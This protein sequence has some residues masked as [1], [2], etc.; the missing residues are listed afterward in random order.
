LEEVGVEQKKAN[1]EK[2][3]RKHMV[4][5]TNPVAKSLRSRTFK[6]KVIQSKKLYNRKKKRIDTL[7]AAAQI[8]L[9][10]PNG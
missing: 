1:L 9:E 10:E 3:W 4:K 7:N 6:P 5:S 2:C 8:K